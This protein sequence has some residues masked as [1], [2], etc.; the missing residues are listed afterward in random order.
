MSETGE[1]NFLTV[2]WSGL[3]PGR[4]PIRKEAKFLTRVESADRRTA[5]FG[6][7]LSEVGEWGPGNISLVG[8]FTSH[9]P[10]FY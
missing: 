7:V 8:T 1:K 10:L 3:V 4:I 5:C 2:V 6:H 9:M